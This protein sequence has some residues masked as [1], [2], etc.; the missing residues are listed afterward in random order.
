MD[1]AAVDRVMASYK[2]FP[3]VERL[4]GDEIRVKVGQYLEKLSIAGH[5]NSDELTYFGETYL[6][7]L[8]W[9][10]ASV[11]IVKNR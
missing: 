7:I 1:T 2:T 6:R 10:R 8:R 5:C 11:T 9:S 4:G 3:A